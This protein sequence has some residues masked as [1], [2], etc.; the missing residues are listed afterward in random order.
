MCDA[1][2]V[3]LTLQNPNGGFASYEVIRGPK[4]LEWLNPAEV[5]GLFPLFLP[6][7]RVSKTASRRHH[8]RILLPGMHYLRHHKFSDFPET[9]S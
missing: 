4:W 2:D 5:F 6:L 9:L 3:M 7:M 8:D 1:I